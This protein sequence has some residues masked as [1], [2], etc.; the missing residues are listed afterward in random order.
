MEK[1]GW[2]DDDSDYVQ[3]EKDALGL[4]SREEIQTLFDLYDFD[5]GRRS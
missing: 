2:R 3:R 5:E 1:R 4:G